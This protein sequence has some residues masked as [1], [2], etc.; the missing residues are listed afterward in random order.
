MNSPTKRGSSVCAV[1]AV[2]L[3]VMALTVIA[4]SLKSPPI[5]V[6]AHSGPVFGPACGAATIDG[7]VNADE[8]S[9]AST[10][11][12]PMY[13]TGGTAP[14]TATLYVMNSGYYLYLGITINDD[15]FTTQGQ[16]LPQGDGFRIDFDND[17]SGSLFAL[18]DNV[19]L[20][21]AGS[22]QFGDD[23]IY[24][25]PSSCR[26]DVEGGGT[27]DGRGAASRVGGLNHFE[28]RHPLCSGDALDFCLH[29]TGVVGFRLQ[30]LDAEADGSFGGSRY[31]PGSTATSEADIVIGQCSARDLFIYLPLLMKK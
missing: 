9:G 29:P 2:V 8:W 13:K 19:L 16:F 31:F 4:A 17:H 22:P 15:E 23:Y 18:G 27:S 20:I 7:V 11:T 12:F 5:P 3:V 26:S 28:L 21:G 24:A 30:Y 10:Q 1:V 14:L 25:L 6:S